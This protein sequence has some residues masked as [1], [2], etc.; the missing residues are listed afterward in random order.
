MGKESFIIPT[1]N[2]GK[3][4]FGMKEKELGGFKL[5]RKILWNKE[6]S[7]FIMNQIINLFKYLILNIK[8]VVFLLILKCNPIIILIIY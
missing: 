8:A 5:N 2:L 1:L 3:K 4:V 6:F 7:I